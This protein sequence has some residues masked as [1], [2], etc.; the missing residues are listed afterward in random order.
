MFCSTL[1]KILRQYSG[2]NTLGLTKVI[3]ALLF[4]GWDS[5]EEWLTMGI[6]L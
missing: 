1:K 5:C 3:I 6:F 2:T 4:L